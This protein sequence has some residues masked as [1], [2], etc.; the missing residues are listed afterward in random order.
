MSYETKVDEMVGEHVARYQA[1]FTL[2]KR[3]ESS[4]SPQPMPYGYP[5]RVY[6]PLHIC[7]VPQIRQFVALTGGRLSN[8]VPRVISMELAGGYPLGLYN[9]DCRSDSS[10][11]GRCG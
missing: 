3:L 1:E 6:H 10:P 7:Q 4:L 9:V 8:R 2:A 5:A 11:G